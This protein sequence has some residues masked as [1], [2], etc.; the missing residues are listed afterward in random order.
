MTEQKP[1]E[2][3]YRLIERGDAYPHC[4]RHPMEE[5]VDLNNSKTWKVQILPPDLLRYECEACHSVRVYKV[6]PEKT[7]L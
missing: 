7:V 4:E 5:L 2:P 1:K 3:Q 6:I